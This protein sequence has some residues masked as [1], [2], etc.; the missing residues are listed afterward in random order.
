MKILTL[1]L[2]FTL[3]LFGKVNWYG[4]HDAIELSKKTDKKIMIVVY[5]DDCPYCA[6][7]FNL[8]ESNQDLNKIVNDSIY[9]VAIDQKIANS[10]G[11]KGVR[12]VPSFLFFDKDL[13]ECTSPVVGLPRDIDSLVSKIRTNCKK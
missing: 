6:G 13:N 5:S 12:D 10:I 11:L 3:S 4:I 9:Q 2:F 1:I 8:L 7:Y